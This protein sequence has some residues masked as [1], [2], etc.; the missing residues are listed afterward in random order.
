MF[1]T[2]K[3]GFANLL[4]VI[5]IVLLLLTATLIYVYFNKTKF[6]GSF[7]KETPNPISSPPTGIYG[8]IEDYQNFDITKETAVF[9]VFKID[10]E[11]K[12]LTLRFII[13]ENLKDKETVAK[14]ECNNGVTF[15]LINEIG[16][17]ESIQKF[18]P[19]AALAEIRPQ[20]ILQ[21]TC[22]SEKCM[23]LVDKC[24]LS[25]KKQLVKNEE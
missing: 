14:L 10:K 22:D 4:I 2:A 5:F 11:N 3:S 25:R 24:F 15:S 8:V 9:Q 21:A 16:I 7:S 1:Q 12:Q 19:E 6:I 18:D 23:L 17:V 20:D 13:P